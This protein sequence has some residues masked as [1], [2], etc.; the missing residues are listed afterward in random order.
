MRE[1]RMGKGA[2]RR[3]GV[4]RVRR[5]GL[6]SILLKNRVSERLTYHRIGNMFP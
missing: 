5:A 3:A 4:G 1:C 6:F 2:S